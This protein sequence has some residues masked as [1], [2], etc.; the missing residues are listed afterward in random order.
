M[1]MIA[2]HHINDPVV[3]HVAANRLGCIDLSSSDQLRGEIIEWLLSAMM[4]EELSSPFEQ[5]AQSLTAI[6]DMRT[7]HRNLAKTLGLT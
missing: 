7:V 2:L 1:Q 6:Q 3:R 5:M 4:D